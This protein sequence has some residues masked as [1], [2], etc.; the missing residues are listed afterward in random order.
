MTEYY[1][2]HVVRPNG[3]EDFKDVAA[4][5]II[6]QKMW[7]FKFHQEIGPSDNAKRDPGIVT[8]NLIYIPVSDIISMK[9]KA[10]HTFDNMQERDKFITNNAKI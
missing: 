1:D 9:A 4:F 6:D 8:A 2:F 5:G 7:W 10:H 3:I